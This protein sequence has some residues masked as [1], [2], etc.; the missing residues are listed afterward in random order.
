MSRPCQNVDKVA[1]GVIWL[2]GFL[3]NL[4]IVLALAVVGLAGAGLLVWLAGIDGADILLILVWLGA[5]VLAGHL[6]DKRDKRK[7]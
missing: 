2:A 1:A 3:V 5:I 6:L 7:S 4:A